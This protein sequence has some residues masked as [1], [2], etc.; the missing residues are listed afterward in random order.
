VRGVFEVGWF[1]V[2]FG[3]GFVVVGAVFEHRISVIFVLVCV[4]FG[5][6]FLFVSL[7]R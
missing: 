5:G 7:E 6:S 2:V 3:C 4:C 1:E